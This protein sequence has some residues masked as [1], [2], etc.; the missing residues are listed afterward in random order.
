MESKEWT[1][2]SNVIKEYTYV[3]YTMC[4][5]LPSTKHESGESDEKS[6]KTSPDLDRC[7]L[8]LEKLQN[9]VISGY[10]GTM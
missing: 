7:H 10:L 2:R 5:L 9:R 4:L 3:Q 1:E 8:L 6:L